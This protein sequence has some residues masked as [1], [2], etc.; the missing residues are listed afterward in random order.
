MNSKYIW[1]KKSIYTNLTVCFFVTFLWY[2]KVF[3]GHLHFFQLLAH[4]LHPIIYILNYWFLRI[5]SCFLFNFWPHAEAYGTSVP[6]PGIE[7]TTAT[8]KG[9]VLT[10]GPPGKFQYTSMLQ[11]VFTVLPYYIVYGRFIEDKDY[12]CE[13]E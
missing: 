2:F 7:P 9:G 6:Q 4:V 11:K 10:T 13:H 1:K 3:T 8:V 5:I 12:F